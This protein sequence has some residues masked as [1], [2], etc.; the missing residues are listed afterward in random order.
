MSF[1]VLLSL[2]ITI[3]YTKETL[4]KLT[5][6]N[7]SL[8]N[9]KIKVTYTLPIPIISDKAHLSYSNIEMLIKTANILKTDSI[10]LVG[11]MPFIQQNKAM[12]FNV[13]IATILIAPYR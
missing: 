3:E 1:T 8:P 12:F 13:G 6:Q 5:K 11:T 4:T 9:R 7:N 10:F 2:P